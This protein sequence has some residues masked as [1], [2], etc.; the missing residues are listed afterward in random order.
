VHA[1]TCM[2]SRATIPMHDMHA[3]ATFRSGVM[4]RIE[5]F[6]SDAVATIAEGGLPDLEL[7]SRT[8]SNSH[9]VVDHRQQQLHDDEEEDLLSGS[10]AEEDAGGSMGGAGEES[11]AVA[12]QRLQ[13]GSDGSGDGS[14]DRDQQHQ[15]AQRQQ[16]R[17]ARQRQRGARVRLGS[18]VQVKSLTSA[19]GR[20][21]HTVA[22]VFRVLEA[23][24]ELLHTGRQ[25]TQRDL[26]YTVSRDSRGLPNMHIH[27]GLC[28]SGIQQP[29]NA[30]ANAPHSPRLDPPPLTT[31]TYTHTHHPPARRPAPVPHRRLRQRR[32]PRRGR[33]FA[34]P[35][36]QPGDC[37]LV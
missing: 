30:T 27:T 26:Y 29:L 6:I 28:C 9:M 21:A 5:G 37:L 20:Q 33:P 25:A 36:Q 24:H 1:A 35:P 19:Q 22:R 3:H 7:V 34:R 31:N 15:A 10:G 23:V 16:S 4:A 14:E 11:A 18:Q 8:A 2:H 12:W 13:V 17:Q 32:H